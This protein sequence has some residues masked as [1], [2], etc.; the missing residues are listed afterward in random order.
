MLLAFL[1]ILAL[2]FL[3]AGIVTSKL[4]WIAVLVVLIVA[5][6]DRRGTYW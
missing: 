3:V 6:L 2:I 5:L 4:F 1:L